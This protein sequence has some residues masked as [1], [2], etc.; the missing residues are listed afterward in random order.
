MAGE[1]YVGG[2]GLG[3]GYLNRPE[4]T[5]EKFVPDG[6]SGEA[7]AR[8]YRTGD[9]G[10][11]SE[12]GALEFLGR[13]DDQIK[14]RGYRIEPGEIEAALS[15]QAGVRQCAVVVREEEPG[16]KRLVAYVVAEPGIEV[17]WQ[18]LRSH[19][20]ARLPDYMAPSSC[21]L[22]SEL[23]LTPNG[24]LDR[25]ALLKVKGQIIT[26]SPGFIPPRTPIEEELAAIWTELLQ[27]ERIGIYDNFFYLG[28][29]SIL[30]TQLVS[31][32]QN[33]FGVQLPIQ[34]LFI[35]PTLADMARAIFEEYFEYENEE[36]L[37]DILHDLEQISPNEVQKYLQEASATSFKAS[38][39]SK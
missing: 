6:F 27:V 2:A 32:V 18:E 28:G 7:G 36:T 33:V 12:G 30:L 19:L 34:S 37:T 4:A 3:R 1:L 10:R 25:Q 17:R 9:L 21:V 23:P 13:I 8:L 39:N 38:L 35:M 26:S 11:W 31:R 5:A 24:K 22:L 15:G 14:I 20:Q 16:D 29:H